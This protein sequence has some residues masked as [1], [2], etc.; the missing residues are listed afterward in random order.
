MNYVLLGKTEKW[1]SYFEELPS[2]PHKHNYMVSLR[3]F[4]NKYAVIYLH[5]LFKSRRIGRIVI[6]NKFVNLR[7][8][9]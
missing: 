1:K 6:K 7:R 3:N 4:V 2:A 8:I 9:K 5:V